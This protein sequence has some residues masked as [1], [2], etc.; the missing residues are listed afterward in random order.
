M[1]LGAIDVTMTA[2]GALA[3][4]LLVHLAL[5]AC[6]QNRASHSR[7][8][9]TAVEELASILR[10]REDRPT[11]PVES[12]SALESVTPQS[13][14][15]ALKELA[16]S[17]GEE[18]KGDDDAGDGRPAYYLGDESVW[19]GEGNFD[20]SGWR[21]TEGTLRFSWALERHKL[22]VNVKAKSGARG[23]KSKCKGS[24]R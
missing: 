9:E 3:W 13:S 7:R 21:N 18:R 24:L 16:K 4:S 5:L 1:R 2:R 20:D 6:A 15:S 17:L 8:D 10:E 12:V 22:T 11:L 14:L 23:G 19:E